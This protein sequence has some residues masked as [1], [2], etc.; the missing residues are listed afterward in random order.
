MIKIKINID[1]KPPN[2]S[3]YLKVLSQEAQ[4]LMDEIEDANNGIDYNKLLFI[5]SNKKKLNFNIFSTPFNFLL[6]IY[7]GDLNKKIE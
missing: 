3:N 4:D 2:V 7:N 6:D 1:T 5:G